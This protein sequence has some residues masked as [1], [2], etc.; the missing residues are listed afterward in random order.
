M[1]CLLLA[2]AWAGTNTMAQTPVNPAVTSGLYQIDVDHPKKGI[3]E[4]EQAAASAAPGDATLQYYLGY[5]YLKV[6]DR[7]KAAAAFDKGISINEKEPLNYAGKGWIALL[8]KKPDEAKAQFEKAGIAKTKNVEVLKAVAEAYLVDNKYSVDAINI[9]NRAKSAANTDPDVQILFGDAYLLQ[10][11]GGASVS[12]YERAASIR[13]TIAKPHYKAGLVFERSKNNESAIENFNKAISIDPQYTLAYKEVAETY[14]LMGAQY[15][16]KALPAFEKYLSLTEDPEKGQE[17]YAFILSLGKN[18]KKANTIFEKLIV[19]PNVKTVTLRFYANSLKEDG[20]FQKS[21]D[22]F[23]KY[24]A[25]AKPEELTPKDYE[26]LASNYMKLK[27]DS[28]GI[29]AL[30]KSLE[31]NPDQQDV[32]QQMGEAQFR[33]RKYADAVDTYQKLM[34][35]RKQKLSSDYFF[36]ARSLYYNK[37][38]NHADTAFVRLIEMQPEMVIGYIWEANTKVQ[39][40]PD[41]EQGLAKPYFEKVIE[42]G[43]SNVEKNKKDIISAYRYLG[44][45]YYNKKEYAMALESYEKLLGLIPGDEETI[46]AIDILKKSQQAPPQKTSKGSK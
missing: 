24:F 43:S 10:N 29:L 18:Y 38:F 23:G 12:A 31:L 19:A 25:K 45:Y 34:S 32:L 21:I 36:L 7:A 15:V 46:K 5:G 37:Q 28:L 3:A 6:N 13:A 33:S 20:E 8:D 11:N 17:L 39:L 42:K 35:K 30:K 40:D 22:V 4:L 44:Y 16:D 27:Q 26:D 1:S 2:C 9:L 41:S 14:Y